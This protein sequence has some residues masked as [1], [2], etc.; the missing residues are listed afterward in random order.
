M[1]R[2]LQKLFWVDEFENEKYIGGDFWL[3]KN[4]DTLKNFILNYC[5]NEEKD[6]F[7]ITLKI[8]KATNEEEEEYNSFDL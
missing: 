4:E 7:R 8:R 2:M 3:S 1:V 5:R 6:N